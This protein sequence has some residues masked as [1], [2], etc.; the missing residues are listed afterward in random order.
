LGLINFLPPFLL[1]F[2]ATSDQILLLRE[3]SAYFYGNELTYGIVLASWLLWGSIGSLMSPR[4]RL[5]PQRFPRLYLAVAVLLPIS[6]LSLR[7]SRFL[8][9]L[10][11]GELSGLMPVFFMS[12][13]VCLLVSFPLGVLFVFNVIRSGGRIEQVFIL[14]SL[15]AAVG[16]ILVQVAVIP[17]VSH[18]QA[19]S[20]VGG[21]S[22]ILVAVSF[23]KKQFRAWWLLIFAALAAF[24]LLDLPSQRKHW[25]PFVLAASRDSLQLSL[26]SNGAH[27][28]SYPDPAA[29]EEAVHFAMLQ[30][31]E[32]Q[33][34]LLVGGGAGGSLGEILKY[35]RAE[36]DYVELDPEIIKLS[37]R[38]LPA[39]ETKFMKRVRVYSTDGRAYLKNF[40]GKYDVIILNLP[41]P[42]TALINRFFTREFFS[43]ARSRLSPG[44]VFSFGVSSAENYIGPELRQFLS[45]LYFT[46]QDVYPLVKIVPGERNIFLASSADLTLS[47]E[48]LVQRM[49]QFGLNTRYVSAAYLFSRLHPLRQKNLTDQVLAGPRKIN[50]DLVPVSF[51]FSSVL[52]SSQ[53][54]GFEKSLLVLI[55]RLSPI[56]LAA[57]P[58]AFFS[59][60]ILFFRIKKRRTADL[61]MPLAVMGLTTIVVEITLL[62]W[63]QAR[64]GYLYGRIALLL[65]SFMLGLFLGSLSASRRKEHSP[66]GLT[67]VQFGF[68]LFLFLLLI[69]V[70]STPPEFLS[71]AL[72]VLMG[73]LSG[74]LFIISNTLYLK[75]K[76]NYGLGYGLDLGGSFCGALITSSILIPLAGLTYVLV[77][78]FLLN[79]LC[80]L[81]LVTRPKFS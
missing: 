49:R 47:P 80:L 71:F 50:R 73:G 79:L 63:Y 68:V 27:V 55:S 51:F 15:G 30:R 4:M 81:F 36:A 56:W 11:P 69:V 74:E 76:L 41:E 57:C 19:V 67:C 72:L 1:G 39:E 35:P 3:F 8:F 53:F 22:T 61:L 17:L 77:I 75:E 46:S 31:P 7:F 6:L 37:Q 10:A 38:Y 59:L 14:E 40:S 18:W 64:Y 65:S 42:S 16:G 48:T 54:S 52:W 60:I 29:A 23:G 34:I 66:A 24:S 26:Y 62:V 58:L 20:L 33:K 25:S 2:L 32:A 70:R 43:L 9:G 45:S 21:L 5:Q 12:L 78:V 13:G 44:G 28:Y